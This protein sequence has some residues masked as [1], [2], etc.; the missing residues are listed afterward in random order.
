MLK[1]I[2]DNKVGFLS[3]MR[4]LD[5]TGNNIINSNTP[6]F[7]RQSVSFIDF[8]SGHPLHDDGTVRDLRGS[9]NVIALTDRHFGQGNM[10]YTGR[11]LDLAINGNGFFRLTREDGSVCYTRDGSF[12]VDAGGRVISKQGYLLLAESLP[13]NYSNIKINE[14]GMLSCKD[15]NGDTVEIGQIELA[16]F[17]H[18]TELEPLGDNLY[19][20]TDAAGEELL[21]VPG[22]EEAGVIIQGQLEGS[23]VDLVT[24][25]NNLIVAQRSTQFNSKIIQTADQLWNIAN[26]LQK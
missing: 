4:K 20:A 26:N 5:V 24:E 18:P 19:Q 16:F 9:G 12:Q 23:N 3:Q 17:T 22:E 25:M 14:K 1:I 10:V 2:G 13:D 7:K 11:Q 21:L 8:L 15:E 6:G